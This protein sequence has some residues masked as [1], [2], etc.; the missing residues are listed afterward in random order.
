MK[1]EVK[2][3]AGRDSQSAWDLDGQNSLGSKALVER[4]N[5][6]LAVTAYICRFPSRRILGEI[7]A[8]ELKSRVLVLSRLNLDLIGTTELADGLLGRG[9]EFDV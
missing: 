7:M 9:W 5:S 8:P 6:G 1:Q 2:A 4:S 3:I